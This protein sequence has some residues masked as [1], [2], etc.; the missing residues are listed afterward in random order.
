MYI[1]ICVCVCVYIVICSFP[2]PALGVKNA[3][4]YLE[5]AQLPS[6]AKLEMLGSSPFLSLLPQS[7][8]LWCWESFINKTSSIKSGAWVKAKC[9]RVHISSCCP[10]FFPCKVF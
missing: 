9:A 3:F 5:A 2:E 10:Y 7:R 1:W 4:Q 6:C 8:S